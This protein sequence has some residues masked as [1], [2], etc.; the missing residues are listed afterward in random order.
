MRPRL[1]PAAALFVFNLLETSAR[2]GDLLISTGDPDG[3]MAMA[4]RPSGNGNIE[5]ESAD[6]F[7]LTQR[8]SITNVTFTGLIQSATTAPSLDPHTEK[9]QRSARGLEDTGFAV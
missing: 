6:D 3:L 8:S 2:C 9:K 7:F 5:I 1:L 4:T